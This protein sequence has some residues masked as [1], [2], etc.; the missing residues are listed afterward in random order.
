V[1][2]DLLADLRVPAE[3]SPQALLRKPGAGDLAGD[4]H[5]QRADMTVVAGGDRTVRLPIRRSCHP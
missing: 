2:P 5:P 4:P 3:R 1:R